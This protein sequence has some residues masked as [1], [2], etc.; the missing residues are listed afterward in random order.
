MAREGIR[1]D[2]S[3]R[4]ELCREQASPGQTDG[5][6]RGQARDDSPE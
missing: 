6:L 2:Y 3:Q 1:P 4:Y 5:S